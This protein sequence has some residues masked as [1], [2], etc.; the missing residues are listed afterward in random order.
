LWA[1]WAGAYLGLGLTEMWPGGCPSRCGQRN[2]LSKA[3]VGGVWASLLV[4]APSID[5]GSDVTVHIA[6]HPWPC[7]VLC[8]V[9]QPL[10]CSCHP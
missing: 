8:G 9:S 1:V 6:V 3:T 4:H 7:A 2:A 10:P 5:A